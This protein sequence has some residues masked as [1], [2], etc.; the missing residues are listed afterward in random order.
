MYFV[1]II[2]VVTIKMS[3]KDLNVLTAFN[4]LSEGLSYETQYISYMLT[5]KV[6]L[7]NNLHRY[8]NKEILTLGD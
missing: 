8:Y 7:Q 2:D 6:Q 4:T 1:F 3:K 5:A